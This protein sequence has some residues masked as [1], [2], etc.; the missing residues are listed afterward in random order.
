MGDSGDEAFVPNM[1]NGS[2]EEMTFKGATWYMKFQVIVCLGPKSIEL[3]RRVAGGL[4]KLW[5]GARL[6]VVRKSPYLWLPPPLV[7][8]EAT[9]K[10]EKNGVELALV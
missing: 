1:E 5:S 9:M 2:M 3:L 8:D 6:E 4:D 7:E 10:L